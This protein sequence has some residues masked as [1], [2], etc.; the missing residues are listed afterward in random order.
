MPG[1]P[2]TARV[3]YNSKMGMVMADVQAPAAP[4]KM[5]YQLWLLPKDG[6]PISAGVFNTSQG[7]GSMFMADVPKGTEPLMFSIT[8]E[9]EGGMP[10]PT[11][12]T[13]M[14]AKIL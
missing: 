2:M 3:L 14:T 1:H 6:P 7:G 5:N 8:L 10:H 9:P 13:L 12:P 11:G 4:E